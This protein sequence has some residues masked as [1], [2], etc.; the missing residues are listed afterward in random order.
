MLLTGYLGDP[1]EKP[2][3]TAQFRDLARRCGQLDGTD[4]DRELTAEDL[5]KIGL[6]VRDAKRILAL[7]S[8]EQQLAWYVQKGKEK[9][10]YPLT[11]VSQGY[12]QVLK[13]RLG[14]ESPGCLWTKGELSLLE[15]PAI[16]LVG[17]RSLGVLNEA[18]AME[19]GRQAALQGY[20]LVSGNATGADT[21]AQ[22]SCL[23]HGGQV[24]SVV[25]DRLDQHPEKENV[26]YLSEQGY[27][28][29]FSAWRALSRNRVI[30]ALPRLTLVVQSRCGKGGTWD[31]TVKNLKNHWSPVFCLDDGSQGINALLD[32][33]AEPIYGSDLEDF[34]KLKS[35]IHPMIDQ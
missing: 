35:V 16:S 14:L 10:C 7:L 33:G 20:V 19:A 9:G 21:V 26:L 24:I 1:N 3:T 29:G 17:S 15:K 28:L 12:P 32:M 8:R 25:A 11:W 18:F 31:G 27:D 13:K 5:S 30:H 23:E 2:M 34:S 22:D 6:N 4:P